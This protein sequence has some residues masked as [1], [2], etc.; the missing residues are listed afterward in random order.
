MGEKISKPG[1]KS[2]PGGK[3]Y[4]CWLCQ[5]EQVIPVKSGVSPQTLRSADFKITDAHYGKTSDVYQCVKCS[6]NFCPDVDEA[7]CFYIDMDDEEYEETRAERA[8]QARKML[9]EIMRFV[10]G[11][12]LLDVGAASGIMVEEASTA[13]FE[14]MGIEPS[15]ALQSR[16]R[17]HG[18]PVVLGVLPNELVGA[19]FNVVT[20]VDVLEHV[21]NPVG[22]LKNIVEVLDEKGICVITTP[23]LGS[24]PSRIL[25]HKWWHYRLAHI[26]YFSAKTLDDAVVAAGMEIVSSSRPCW[27]F[28]ASYLVNRV[29]SYFPSWFR[30]PLPKFLDRLIIPLNLGDS[31]QVICRKRI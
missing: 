8:L 22:I 30:V 28:P 19:G 5:A 23:D 29:L 15:K 12:R 27:Y 9:Q 17:E 1:Q 11:G 3:N 13:G 25:G 6:F 10:P 31:I 24:L 21:S 20:L 26:A 2:G 16:A 7:L 18:L 14:A 4:R